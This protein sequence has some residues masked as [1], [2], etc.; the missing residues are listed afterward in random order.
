L[1]IQ[2]PEKRMETLK[3]C[4]KELLRS[5]EI[6][7]DFL[8]GHALLGKVYQRMGEY[9]KAIIHFKKFISL[10]NTN[11]VVYNNYGTCYGFK[12][13]YENAKLNFEKAIETSPICYSDA[14]CNLGAVYIF[15][16]QK[17]LQENNTLESQKAYTKSIEFFNKTL[18][19]DKNYANAY[20]YLGV[21][22]NALG[23]T[24]KASSYTKRGKELA[25]E[26][27]QKI[28]NEKK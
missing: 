19:C 16:G 28:L 24:T 17:Y 23:D 15:Y 9:D 10:N 12:G 6:Y 13:D 1:A 18:E 14:L 20:S 26:H 11:P 22:Y 5:V 7:D 25:E 2:T 21:S 3:L 8:D 4:E 27:T